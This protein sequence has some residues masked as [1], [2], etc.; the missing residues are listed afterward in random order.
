[1]V[2][3]R[4]GPSV[5]SASTADFAAWAREHRRELLAQSAFLGPSTV[6]LLV[7]FAGLRAYLGRRQ[8]MG[9]VDLSLVVLAGGAAWAT[10]NLLAQ[11]L[12]VSLALAAGGGAADEHVADLGDRM[13]DVLLVGNVPVAA[14]IAAT[15]YLGARDRSLPGWLVVLSYVTALAHAAPVATAGVTEGPLSREG[16]LSYLP[17]PLFVAWVVGV[18]VTLLRRGREG[19]HAA[20]GKGVRVPLLG[21]GFRPRLAV[22][23]D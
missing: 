4:A 7:F 15:G 20:S 5:L 8:R 11:G 14:A 2:F 16:A 6:P 10:I 23:T 19:T 22:W 21:H 3:E 1:M 17:Y 13:I 12:Q 9:R 18:A